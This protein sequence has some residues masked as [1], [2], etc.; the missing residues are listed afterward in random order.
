MVI[1]PMTTRACRPQVSISRPPSAEPV[2]EAP[3]VP[4]RKNTEAAVAPQRPAPA[5]VELAVPCG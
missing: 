2:N 1:K 4:P 5:A 3:N